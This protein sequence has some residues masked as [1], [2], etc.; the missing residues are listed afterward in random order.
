MISL[1]TETIIRLHDERV[2]QAHE[3]QGLVPDKSLEAAIARI[4][5]RLDYGLIEDVFQLA[6]CYAAFIAEAH[7]FNDANKRTAFAAMDMILVL[8]GVEIDYSPQEAGDMIIKIV[9]K[10]IDETV[11]AEWLRSLQT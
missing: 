10:Q 2:I 7:A 1:T 6:A 9:T 5:T 8:N 3:L 11:L 4:D